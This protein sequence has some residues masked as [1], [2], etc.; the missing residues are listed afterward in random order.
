ML[1][2]AFPRETRVDDLIEYSLNF[3]IG[4]RA[5][6]IC[7]R[8]EILGFVKKLKS[9]TAEIDVFRAVM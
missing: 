8:L 2:A 1:V 4:F 5:T 7:G 6:A 3:R 9:G